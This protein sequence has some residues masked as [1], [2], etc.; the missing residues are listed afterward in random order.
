MLHVVIL[1][2]L[3]LEVGRKKRAVVDAGVYTEKSQI[4][5]RLSTN[6]TSIPGEVYSKVCVKLNVERSR[7]FDDFRMLAEKVGLSRDETAVIE[8][9]YPENPTD[10]ILKTWSTKSREATVEKLIELLQEDGFERIDVAK[11]LEDW[12]FNM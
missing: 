2:V 1:I 10:E 9:D 11:L 3:C 8:Q 7:R 4:K 5:T 12:V 6:V